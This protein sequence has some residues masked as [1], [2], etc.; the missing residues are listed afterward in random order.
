MWQYLI[1]G[2][3]VVAAVAYSVYRLIR[4]FKDPLRKC[5]GCISSCGG[6]P[7]EEL[8]KVPGSRV[9]VES[10]RIKGQGLSEAKSP[11]RESRVWQR[12]FK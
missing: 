6:C 7:L 8:K 2:L 4:Y 12:S 9:K 1:T 10:S 3:V 11:R 5:K